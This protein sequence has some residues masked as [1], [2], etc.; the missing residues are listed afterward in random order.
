MSL[1]ATLIR[2]KSSAIF[3]EYELL[4][5]HNT[6]MLM[7]AFENIKLVF[8][9]FFLELLFMLQKCAIFVKGVKN[10]NA[11]LSYTTAGTIVAVYFTYGFAKIF[12]CEEWKSFKSENNDKNNMKNKVYFDHYFV[13]FERTN[14]IFSLT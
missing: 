5:P 2:D 1:P 8:F 4:S 10:L 11:K 3:S 7:C 9:A 13:C 14:W 12:W 6:V